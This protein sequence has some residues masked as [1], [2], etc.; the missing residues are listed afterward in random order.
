MMSPCV[1]LARSPSAAS[2]RH[3]SHVSN[4]GAMTMA[5]SRPFP[6]TNFTTDEGSLDR[7]ERRIS[8]WKEE[9]E[10]YHHTRIS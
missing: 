6:R 2:E 3:T 4:S 1:G 8:P 9:E 10:H 7:S 5:L